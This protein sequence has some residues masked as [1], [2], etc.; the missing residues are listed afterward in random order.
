MSPI[1]SILV[2]LDGC[3]RVVARLRIA[4]QLAIAHEAELTGLF[5]VAPRFVPLVEGVP[6]A[7][8]VN[9]I[10]AK[11]LDAARQHFEQT[12]RNGAKNASLI[13]LTGETPIPAFVQYAL[14]AELLVLGQRDPNDANGFDLP[15]DFVEA[16]IIDSGKPALVIPYTGEFAAMPQTA[17]IAWKPTREAARALTGALPLLQR[18]RSVHVVCAEEAAFDFKQTRARLD[19]YL[20]RHGIKGVHEH[21]GLGGIDVGNGLLS[22][23]SDVG[24]DLLVMGCYGHSRAR[25]LVLGGASRLVLESMTLPVL[26]AH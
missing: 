8:L 23:A 11:H 22:L 6:E 18:A 1:R 3:E 16:V 19:E 25:E 10:D 14:H 15:S 24:A 9:Q 20:L 13:E 4:H 7:P 2:H 21:L 17:L 12:V 26:M 5:A